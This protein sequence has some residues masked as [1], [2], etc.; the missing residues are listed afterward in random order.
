[1]AW[2]EE[3]RRLS[4]PDDGQRRDRRTG[5][6]LAGKGEASMP[7]R[8]E[9]CLDSDMNDVLNHDTLRSTYLALSESSYPLAV[10]RRVPREVQQ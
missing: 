10:G 5:D 3:P 7:V 9:R 4:V 8:Y 1:M 2:I 6:E